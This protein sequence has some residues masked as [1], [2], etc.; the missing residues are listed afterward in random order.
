MPI[1]FEPIKKPKI[2]FEPIEE[3]SVTTI[4]FEPE[5]KKKTSLGETFSKIALAPLKPFRTESLTQPI[6]KQLTGKSLGE[7]TD[8]LNKASADIIKKSNRPISVPEAFIRQLPAATAQA[9]VN[10][11][12][13]SPLDVAIMQA[14]GGA[15]KIPVKGTTLGKIASKIPIGKGFVKGIETLGE[16]EI[17]PLAI[18]LNN[19]T[20]ISE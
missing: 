12:D 4:D 3:S 7:R 18:K 5:P 14:T 13:L 9:A 1:N 15:G 19:G 10:L 8:F 6:S 17:L 11:V 20:I 2:N 16:K